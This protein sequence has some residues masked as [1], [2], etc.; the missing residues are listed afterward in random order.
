MATTIRPTRQQI[1]GLEAVLGV[2]LFERLPAIFPPM[3]FARAIV[4]IGLAVLVRLAGSDYA[5]VRSADR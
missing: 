5:L 1:R 2:Q 4:A 3:V